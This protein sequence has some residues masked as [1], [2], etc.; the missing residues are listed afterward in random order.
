M[1][2]K[3]LK[4]FGIALMMVFMTGCYKYDTGMTIKSDKTVEL[5][6]TVAV[7]KKAM[8]QMS[9]SMGGDS[10]S[11]DPDSLRD[12]LKID[13]DEMKDNGYTIENYE[14]ISSDHEWYGYT[15]TKNLGSIDDLLL[16]KYEEVEL[17]N[18]DD[19]TASEGST[20]FEGKKIF[21]KDGDVYK[22]K[23]VYDFSTGDSSMDMSAYKDMFDFK[24]ELNVP[25]KTESN[26]ATEVSSDGSKLTWN[27]DYGKKNTVEFAVKLDKK[28]LDKAAKKENNGTSTNYVV[29]GAVVGAAVGVVVF[30]LKGKKSNTT[31]E[32]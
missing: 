7:D 31:E 28:A 19:S 14:N 9:S 30:L 8:E 15:I 12:S 2:K 13:E 22:A 26:N 27:L 5:K 11:S 4:L 25:D 1:I 20:A 17:Y 18:E 32:N 10:S 29:I 3:G 24:F 21:Y 16:D 6:M 23:L